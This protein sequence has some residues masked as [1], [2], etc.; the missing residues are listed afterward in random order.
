MRTRRRG[1]LAASV[2]AKTTDHVVP[3]LAFLNT[4]R[5]KLLARWSGD[6]ESKR[7]DVVDRGNTLGV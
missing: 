2:S 6:G 3:H 7:E 1:G 5:V 4:D